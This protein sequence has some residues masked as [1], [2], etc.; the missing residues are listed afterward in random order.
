MISIF[1]ILAIVAVFAFSIR[2]M[3]YYAAKRTPYHIYVLVFVAWTMA[4][5]LVALL[6]YDVYLVPST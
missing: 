3:L 2:L 6:P 5:G 4:F 1:S